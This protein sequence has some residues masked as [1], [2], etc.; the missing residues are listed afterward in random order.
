[1]KIKKTD[2][3]LDV[4]LWIMFG[5]LTL[6]AFLFTRSIK[7]PSFEI[8][9]SSVKI[10]YVYSSEDGERFDSFYRLA[11]K[12]EAFAKPIVVAYDNATG[13]SATIKPE[14]VDSYKEQMPETAYPFYTR[15]TLV[16]LGLL[17]VV[18]AFFS[19]WVGGFFRDAILLIM[20]K[21]D[22]TFE[23]CAYYLYEDRVAFRPAAKKLIGAN[24]RQYLRTKGNELYRKY[25]PEFAGLLLHIL[26]SV[27][28]KNDT[29]ITYYLTFSN[30]TCDQ[31][32]YLSRLRSYWDGMIGKNANAEKNVKFLNEQLEKNFLQVNLLVDENDICA[33]T[34][35]QLNKLFTNILGSE[36]LKFYA[37]TNRY[38]K[39]AKFENFIFVDI[40]VRNH[41]NTFTWSGSAV[42]AGTLIPGLE[43]EFKIYH[44][45]KGEE[46]KLWDKYLR[47]VCSYRAKDEE[48]A[49]SEL[50]KKMVLDT[51]DSFDT[52]EKI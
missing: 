28:I 11:Y 38:A 47:P 16:I 14:Y 31:K 10:P 20:L 52:S 1:M 36:V 13:L 12:H 26:T 2:K 50:Y 46:K 4:C 49:S 9:E 29:E 39:A 27:A 3:A 43:I 42:P 35:K 17:V 18:A 8:V 37:Y 5:L 21:G 23:N 7:A 51:I 15:W 22:P 34:N 30:Q 40:T 41:V 25:N 45:V 44:H 33:A 48:F 6:G 32:R 24:I 19:Y